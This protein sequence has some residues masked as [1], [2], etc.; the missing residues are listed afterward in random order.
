MT[1]MLQLLSSSATA[2]EEGR[3]KMMLIHLHKDK[4]EMEIWRKRVGKLG[5]VYSLDHRLT[6][7]ELKEWISPLDFDKVIVCGP[8]GYSFSLFLFVFP[9]VLV[10][11]FSLVCLLFMLVVRA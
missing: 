6:E 1:P 2:N 3:E 7:A 4:E 11:V 9:C 8:K 10:V 5:K